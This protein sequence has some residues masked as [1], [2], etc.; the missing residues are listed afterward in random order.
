MAVT[1]AQAVQAVAHAQRAITAQQAAKVLA[2]LQTGTTTHGSS[3]GA[4]V[5]IEPNAVNKKRYKGLTMTVKFLNEKYQAHSSWLDLEGVLWLPLLLRKR[6]FCK[7]CRRDMVFDGDT[8]GK[9]VGP[10]HNDNVKASLK[11]LSLAHALT[12]VFEFED[13]KKRLEYQRDALI[14]ALLAAGIPPYAM[15]R[16]FDEDV[17]A[18]L[19]A[20][21]SVPTQNTMRDSNVPRAVARVKDFMRRDLEGKF[22]SI[23]V[24]GGKTWQAGGKTLLGVMA[25]SPGLPADLWL[26]TEAMQHPEDSDDIRAVVNKRAAEFKIDKQYQASLVGDNWSGNPKAA[27]KLGIPFSPCAPHSCALVDGGFVGTFPR[28]A[29]FLK[30]VHGF[31]KRG[32]SVKRVAGVTEFGLSLNKLDTVETRW[33][34]VMTAALYLAGDQRWSDLAKARK[35]LQAAAELGDGGAAVPDPDAAAALKDDEGAQPRPVWTVLYEA[36]D[37]MQSDADGKD[38]ILRYLTDITFYAE[39]WA[40]AHVCATRPQVYADMQGSGGYRAIDLAGRL[41]GV[42]KAYADMMT[43]PAAVVT[44]VRE[45][46]RLRLVAVADYLRR[47]GHAKAADRMAANMDAELTRAATRI[48]P[49]LRTAATSALKSVSHLDEVVERLKLKARFDVNVKPVEPQQPVHVYLGLPVAGQLGVAATRLSEQWMSYVTTYEVSGLPPKETVGGKQVDASP[50]AVY[51]YW[52][53]KLSTWPDLAKRALE[54]LALP[55]GNGRLEGGFSIVASMADKDRLCMGVESFNNE[56]FLRANQH[57]VKELVGAARSSIVVTAIVAHGSAGASGGS[58]AG[59]RSA[60]SGAGERR[61]GRGGGGGGGGAS[62]GSEASGGSDEDDDGGGSS[63][64]STSSGGRASRVVAFSATSQPLGKSSSRMGSAGATAPL[65][66]P[67]VPVPN[68]R[69]QRAKRTRA[70][71]DDYD[72]DEDTAGAYFASTR[73]GAD[74]DLSHPAAMELDEDADSEGAAATS[75]PAS[76]SAAH[77]AGSAKRKRLG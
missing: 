75:A 19:T 45:A 55:V 68:R 49:M 5:G 7:Y 16:I 67:G 40:V 11:Q 10:I 46:C 20:V 74:G 15:Q 62:G 25:S 39:V 70:D 77:G 56:L 44:A 33:T 73:D 28:V 51:A 3:L 17:Y 50:A 64:S 48:K 2:A 22:V 59:A 57:Y 14:A 23:H 9:H 38:D 13:A 61:G 71:N 54:T 76:S 66:K 36:V 43:D 12:P 21:R 27:G 34:S 72:D 69:G 26:G 35:S 4:I 60:Q 6:V 47:D 32:F 30:A 63:R 42:R 18:L 31:V 52:E 58:G 1:G 53:S 29:E 65:G 8:L 41:A 24:D 37:S